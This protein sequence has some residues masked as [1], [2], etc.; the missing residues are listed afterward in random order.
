[1]PEMVE[2]CGKRFQVSNRVVKTCTSGTKAGSSMRVFRTDDVVLL[3]GLRCSG[4]D[5]DG[6]QKACVIFWREAWLRGVDDPAVQAVVG[7][8]REQ[9]LARLKTSTGPQSYFCQAGELLKATDHLSRGERFTKCFSEIR[10]GNCSIW[11]MAGRIGTWLIWRIRR[12][13]LGAYARGTNK[14]TP[15]ECL[16]LQA[17]EW[18]EIKPIEIIIRTLDKTANNRGLWFSPD[19][20]LLCGQRRQVEKRVDK[21]ITDGTGQMRQLRNTVFLEGSYCGCAHVAFGGCSRR[22]YVYWR[23]IWLDRA[24]D[25]R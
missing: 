6:C 9:L 18:V 25:S 12:V 17:K 3:D 1:M 19:M 11:E 7:V 22:E 10:T 15:V 16:N 4:A 24:D 14:S 21:I 13:F 20:R 5:H 2:F 8:G 23:E